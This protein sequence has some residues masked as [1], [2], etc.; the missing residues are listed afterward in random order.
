MK[1][2]YDGGQTFVATANMEPVSGNRGFS[3]FGL[4]KAEGK[5]TAGLSA[6]PLV[7]SNG[8]INGANMGE[9][10]RNLNT[11]MAAASS[12]KVQDL[13]AA[14]AKA[15][16]AEKLEQRQVLANAMTSGD[17]ATQQ[18]LAEVIG[19]QVYETLGRAGFSRKFLS[20]KP[21]ARGGAPH[22][23]P[24]IT[25]DVVSYTTTEN[26][27]VPFSQIRQ[28]VIYPKPRVIS[29]SV[30]IDQM[31]LTISPV[32]LLDI[33]YN[34]A[35]EQILVGEDRLFKKFADIAS[36]G[37]NENVFFSTL[38][39]TVL[40]SIR[41]QIDTQGGIPVGGTLIS[42][43]IWADIISE[44]EFQNFYSPVEKHEIVLTGRLGTLMGLDLVTDGFRIPNLKVLDQGSV[45]VFG[46]PD[47][48]GQIGQYDQM[49]VAAVDQATIG[50]FKKGWFLNNIIDMT[51]ANA[52]ACVKGQRI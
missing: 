28:N 9:F 24:V 23:I 4:A 22:V 5:A 47:T 14:T 12:G 48:L 18:A 46:I 35:L 16:L 52:R 10:M 50:V 34:Q 49:S 40:A 39:P 8:S 31:E 7:G 32:D 25:P 38:T 21:L 27:N 41:N 3:P 13:S 20:V 19:E 51:F 1:T 43:D 42:A 45:Y 37:Y 15:E 11:L 29:A 44:S 33:K 36:T 26:S 30:L 2:P 6:D 17:T